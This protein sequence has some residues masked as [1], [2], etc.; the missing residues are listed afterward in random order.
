MWINFTQLKLI[1][2]RKLFFKITI[3]QIFGR[4]N[5]NMLL[6][7]TKKI[8]CTAQSNRYIYRPIGPV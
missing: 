3:K 6:I 4:N 7:P 5:N 8:M 2:L 1:S